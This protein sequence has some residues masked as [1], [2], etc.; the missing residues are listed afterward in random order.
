MGPPPAGLNTGLHGRG[1]ARKGKKNAWVWL[2]YVEKQ[3]GSKASNSSSSMRTLCR[4][5]DLDMATN[6]QKEKFAAWLDTVH[7]AAEEEKLQQGGE[8][9]EVEGSG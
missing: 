4:G 2:H 6:E 5:A 7:S 1:G 3:A 9:M 8:P